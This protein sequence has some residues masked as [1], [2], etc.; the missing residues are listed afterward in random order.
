MKTKGSRKPVW[1]L[2]RDGITYSMLSKFLICPERFR[3]A[4]VEGWTDASLNVPIEFGN[5]FHLCLEKY[6][7]EGSI[8]TSSIRDVLRDYLKT[9]RKGPKFSPEQAVDLE[10]VL[11]S[12]EAVF[13]AY[14]AYWNENPTFI[15]KEEIDVSASSG[16]VNRRK[17]KETRIFDRDL[18]YLEQEA[19]F[20]VPHVLPSGRVVKLRGRRDGVFL[21]PTDNT[22]WLLEN[23]TKGNIDE[24]GLQATLHK[25]AQTMLY[26]YTISQATFASKDKKGKT[27]AFDKVCPSGVIYNV[28]RRPGLRPKKGESLPQY[29]QRI[30]DDIKERPRHYFMRW[31]VDLTE[32]DLKFWVERTLN[33]VLER[34]V[35]W[36]ESI[37]HNPFDPWTTPAPNAPWEG[38]AEN[39]DLVPNPH[40]YERPFGIYDSSQ[41]S[42]RGDFF[43]PLARNNYFGYY[44][45]SVP[46][47]ELEED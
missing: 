24:E 19:K 7:E 30:H 3:L 25:D 29:V 37:K 22:V 18:I 10:Y 28:I 17:I 14:V 21:H 45:R 2:D 34:I 4:S 8:S 16:K 41:F 5:V 11:G 9:R 1:D 46:F 33:P 47:P 12:V 23:K 39:E 27:I 42:A 36:W 32:A 6:E 40:H 35:T 20:E 44:Q 13:P 38:N 31:K 15:I 43:E 26:S